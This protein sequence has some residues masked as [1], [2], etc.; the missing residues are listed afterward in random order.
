[1]NSFCNTVFVIVMQIKLVVVV[2]GLFSKIIPLSYTVGFTLYVPLTN[3]SNRGRGPY[4][5]LRTEFF[6]VDLF[7]HKSTGRN[8]DSYRVYS[9]DRENKVSKL[10][11]TSLRLIGRAGKETR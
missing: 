10:F 11:I 4:F 2:A 1:M 9:T 8:E 5:T 3:A 7:S 6:P